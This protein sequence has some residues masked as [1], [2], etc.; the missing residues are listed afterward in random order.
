MNE[1]GP[2]FTRK[3]FSQIKYLLYFAIFI[4]L[5]QVFQ[6]ITT[7]KATR[8]YRTL[9]LE[10]SEMVILTNSVSF[11]TS[12]IHRAVLNLSFSTD[13]TDLEKFRQNVIDSETEID[14]NIATIEKK[15]ITYNLYSLEKTLL[16]VNLKHAREKHEKNYKDYLTLLND[17]TKAFYFKKKILRPALESFQR[18]QLLFIKRI[19]VDQRILIDA[20]ADD[21]DKTGFRLLITG[22][23]LLGLAVIII[24]YI[25]LSERKKLI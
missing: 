9:F 15:I 16:F 18:H 22:N 13:S 23:V 4:I 21:A 17:S 5:F 20:I 3:E 24:I 11:E 1:E 25:L 6:Y 8:K 12:S 14:A 10:V 19:F 2:R 7:K